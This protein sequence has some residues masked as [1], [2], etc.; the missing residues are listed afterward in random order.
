MF[1][2]DYPFLRVHIILLL[3]PNHQ[4]YNFTI[5]P[6][7]LNYCVVWT[8]FHIVPLNE[9]PLEWKIQLIK[10]LVKLT[11][12]AASVLIYINL[13]RKHISVRAPR[14]YGVTSGA[15]YSGVPQKVF[16]VAPSVM[17]SLHSPKSV[18]FMWPSLSNMRFSSCVG[19]D[20]N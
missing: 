6:F 10:T 15:R 9:V 14:N 7:Q 12:N 2:V 3:Y 13:V 5:S 19:K 11:Q 1:R 17:P 8:S 18:I 4:Q 20:S 16:M